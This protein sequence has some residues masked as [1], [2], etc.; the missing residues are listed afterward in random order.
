[1]AISTLLFTI[2]ATP[3]S[4]LINLL[5]AFQRFSD[6]RICKREQSLTFL[7]TESESV[8]SSSS[9]ISPLSVPSYLHH[10]SHTRVDRHE[11]RLNSFLDS[12]NVDEN[13]MECLDENKENRNKAKNMS[14]KRGN[15]IEFVAAGKMRNETKE[16]YINC[17]QHERADNGDIDK[18]YED[19]SGA[20]LNWSV[21][22]DLNWDIIFLLGGGFALSEGFQ[23]RTDISNRCQETD[24]GIFYSV[25]PCPPSFLVSLHLFLSS[26][27]SCR[28]SFL[29]LLPSLSFLSSLSSF[30]AFL[31]LLPCLQ[32]FPLPFILFSPTIYMSFYFSSSLSS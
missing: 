12:D 13:D 15:R 30:L 19:R 16:G 10:S 28:P 23:V 25:Y 20:I 3:P 29:V 6:N 24:V 32:S 7:D 11:G 1:M 8:S 27:L 26:L 4:L 31:V 5:K 9:A 14:F 2:P 18:N 21:V 17:Q 22:G